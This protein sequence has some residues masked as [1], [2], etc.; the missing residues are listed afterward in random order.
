MR[1]G[2]WQGQDLSSEIGQCVR[3]YAT[4][5][6]LDRD[7]YDAARSQAGNEAFL[8]T[9]QALRQ[10]AW[11]DDELTEMQR[12]LRGGLAVYRLGD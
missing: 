7:L 1:Y 6:S 11:H 12:A 5:E 9:C 3:P 2:S 10:D 8:T 4:N